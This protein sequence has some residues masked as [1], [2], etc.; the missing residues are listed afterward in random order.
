MF[1]VGAG[2]TSIGSGTTTGCGASYCFAFCFF[3]YKTIAV[4][5]VTVYSFTFSDCLL[6][7]GAIYVLKDD[8]QKRAKSV[9][10]DLYSSDLVALV[11]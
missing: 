4:E 6:L 1:V 10:S 7:S 8:F 3:V 9:R 5:R 2:A 11:K